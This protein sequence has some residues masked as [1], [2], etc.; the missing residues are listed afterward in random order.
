MTRRGAAPLV[1]S[2]W[3]ATWLSRTMQLCP[4]PSVTQN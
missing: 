4:S 1:A 3:A 2:T